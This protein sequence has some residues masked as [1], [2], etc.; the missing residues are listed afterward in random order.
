M[1]S[2]SNKQNNRLKY[3]AYTCFETLNYGYQELPAEYIA[4]IFMNS[5][6]V[7]LRY[8]SVTGFQC[9]IVVT[10]INIRPANFNN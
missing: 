1:C 4:T 5:K 10:L 6:R 2:D 8:L 9:F 7:S 3:V